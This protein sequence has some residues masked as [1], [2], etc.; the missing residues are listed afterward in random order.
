MGYIVN[1]LH[2]VEILSLAKNK[3]PTYL[4]VRQLHA[5]D[6]EAS[7]VYSEWQ[8]PMIRSAIAPE[9]ENSERVPASIK[10][11]VSFASR[12]VH[13]LGCHLVTS[14]RCAD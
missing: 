3:R 12:P 2:G 5:S 6:C 4:V 1:L 14:C 7:C 10:R 13:E 9:M 8:T 11:A